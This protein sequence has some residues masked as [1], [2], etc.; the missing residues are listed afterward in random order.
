[1]PV[2][3]P[4]WL[5]SVG[6]HPVKSTDDHGRFPFPGDFSASVTTVVA[7]YALTLVVTLRVGG[8]LAERFGRRPVL[9]VAASGAAAWQ[10]RVRSV[11]APD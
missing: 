5:L 4:P 8:R 9:L 11:T 1:M 3:V 7:T 2:C 10:L 6:P